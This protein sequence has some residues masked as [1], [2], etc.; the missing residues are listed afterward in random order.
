ML[1]SYNNSVAKNMEFIM[2]R[3]FA[4]LGFRW[5]I[6]IPILLLAI[7]MVL[8]GALGMQG[9]SQ[10]ADSSTRLTHRHLPAISLLLNAD[11]DLYQAFIA[12]RSLLDESA[13]GYADELRNSHAE[14][15][16]Q[17]YERVHKYAGMQTSDEAAALVAR[18]D[19]GF[20]RWKATSGRVME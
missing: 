8:M 16:Q 20:L 4:D 19:E 10:V 12:E 17:A 7:L 13:I 14:N 15:L 18:F 9:I 5:K 11:R 1:N 2:L 6:A 3:L